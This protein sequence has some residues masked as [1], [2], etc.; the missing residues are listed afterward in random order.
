MGQAQGQVRHRVRAAVKTVLVLV[1]GCGTVISGCCSQAVAKVKTVAPVRLTS[2]INR[3][4]TQVRPQAV[5]VTSVGQAQGQGQGQ[6]RHRA[7]VVLA[8]VIGYGTATC[9][10]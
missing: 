1:L 6:G 9:G 5:I 7:A 4:L 2:C 10:C 3:A 8:Q